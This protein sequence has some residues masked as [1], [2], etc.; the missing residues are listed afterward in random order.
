[1]R[2]IASVAGDEKGEDG[3]KKKE[4][5]AMRDA[6]RVVCLRPWETKGWKGLEFVSGKVGSVEK[7]Q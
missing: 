6:Q 1:M 7:V 2:S 4:E 5:E 3:K